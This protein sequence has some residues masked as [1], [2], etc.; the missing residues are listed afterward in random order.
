LL[1]LFQD[2]LLGGRMGS[3]GRQAWLCSC[4]SWCKCDIYGVWS[5]AG[6]EAGQE[7]R[8]LA[9]ILRTAWPEAEI[10]TSGH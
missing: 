5:S 10:T 4:A 8:D 6:A 3:V 9:L 1:V 7:R 2:A